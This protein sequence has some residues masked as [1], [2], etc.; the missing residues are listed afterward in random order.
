MVSESVCA[1]QN[2]VEIFLYTCIFEVQY[3]FLSKSDLSNFLATC[4]E[5]LNVVGVGTFAGPFYQ[6]TTNT[7]TTSPHLFTTTTARL[8]IRHPRTPLATTRSTSTIGSPNFYAQPESPTAS[9]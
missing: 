1:F 4:K 3:F 8:P 7:P 6:P 9:P 5:I 2:L